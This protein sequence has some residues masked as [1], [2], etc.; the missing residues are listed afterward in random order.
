MRH[1]VFRQYRL[2]RRGDIALQSGGE[3]QQ[4]RLFAK[5]ERSEYELR[6]GVGTGFEL[7]GTPEQNL[8]DEERQIRR[9]AQRRGKAIRGNIPRL[10][11]RL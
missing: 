6:F 5:K 1:V 7:R 9:I 11:Q 8:A 10:C 4:F 2:D 3:R